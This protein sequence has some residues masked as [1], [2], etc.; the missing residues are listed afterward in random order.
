MISPIET[1][2]VVCHCHLSKDCFKKSVTW[3]AGCFKDF[4]LCRSHSRFRRQT[5]RFYQSDFS[6]DG[7]PLTFV[8]VMFLPCNAAVLTFPE[9][10]VTIRCRHTSEVHKKPKL[11]W[12]AY[13]YNC[14]AYD[15]E[16]T[17]PPVVYHAR[18][19]CFGRCSE[20]GGER[21][22]RA[23]YALCSRSPEKL[24]VRR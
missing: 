8:P 14:F 20:R 16:L 6:G 21:H 17:F 3:K 12:K 23:A 19:G 22:Y 5:R 7:L 13:F 4:F 2:T 1:A 9:A 18:T 10:T 24:G 15:P 11:R